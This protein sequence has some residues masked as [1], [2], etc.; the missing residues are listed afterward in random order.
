MATY[1]A[2]IPDDAI[3]LTP[4]ATGFADD[5]N[6]ILGDAGTPTDGFDDLLAGLQAYS[7]ESPAV[8]AGLD[9]E[10]GTLD[11]TAPG[12]AEP[13][14]QDALNTYSETLAQ[15]QPFVDAFNAKII[16]ATGRVWPGT[17]MTALALVDSAR[18][19]NKGGGGTVVIAHYPYKGGLPIHPGMDPFPVKVALGNEGPDFNPNWVSIDLDRVVPVIERVWADA[20]TSVFPGEAWHFYLDINPTL[21]GVVAGEFP[22]NVQLHNDTGGISFVACKV[23]VTEPPTRPP[24][25]PPGGAAP[26]FSPL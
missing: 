22:F 26:I 14:E 8:L 15:G 10:L 4:V 16:P 11:A 12:L 21:P 13:I 17:M 7:D 25:G 2:L 1:P 19:D 24:V 18:T 23:V 5:L 9:T 6:G 3:D 20:F